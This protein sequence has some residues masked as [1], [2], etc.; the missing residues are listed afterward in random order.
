[1]QAI[2]T[3]IIP[4]TNYRGTRISVQAPAG[5]MILS[6]GGKEESDH[7]EAAKHFA[8]KY[9]WSVKLASGTLHDGSMVHVIVD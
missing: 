7:I 3:K 1:M 2:R 8:M 9:G 6:A 4:Q 5:R